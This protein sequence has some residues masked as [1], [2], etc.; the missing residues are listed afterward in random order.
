MGKGTDKMKRIVMTVDSNNI[1]FYVVLIFKQFT[2]QKIEN[3]L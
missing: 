1:L 3:K 2:N